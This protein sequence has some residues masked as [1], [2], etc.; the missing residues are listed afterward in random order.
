MED[1]KL[2]QPNVENEQDEKTSKTSAHRFTN[3]QTLP[4][5]FPTTEHNDTA[6]ENSEFDTEDDDN[7]LNGT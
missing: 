4:I 2:L 6:I 7:A 1:I 3:C 5:E